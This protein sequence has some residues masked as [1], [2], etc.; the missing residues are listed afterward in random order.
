[1]TSDLVSIERVLNSR[2]SSDFGPRK[3]HFGTFTDKHPPDEVVDHVLHWCNI[4]RFSEGRLLHWFK[5]GYL[6]LGFENPKDPNIQ[7]LL[8]IESGMQQEAVY[9]GCAAE[10]VGT[11][12]DNQGINGTQYGKDTATAKHLIMEI[13]NPYETG[14]LTTRSPGPQKPFVPGKNLSEPRRDGDIEPNEQLLSKLATFNK[15]GPS[16]NEKGIS[17]LLWAARGRTPHC[18]ITDRWNLMW[19]LTIPTWGG[20][21]DYTTVD[22]AMGGKLYAYV[23]WTKEFSLMNRLFREKLRWTRGNPTH[24]LRFVGN[25]DISSQMHGYEKAILLCQNENTG[26]ALWEVGY[27][28]E[29]MLLQA[30]SLGVSYESKIFSEG[31]MSQ[32]GKMGVANAVAAFFI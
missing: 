14:K 4:P 2:C 10:G 1:M 27:M 30:K 3:V 26:R 12:I 13:A 11:C 7:R 23:N 17:Q 15:S 24:D 18:I 32:L 21:Q 28:I 9:L 16:A 8:N 6:F 31:E 29:N 5:N 22:L 25:V 19:G 20:G